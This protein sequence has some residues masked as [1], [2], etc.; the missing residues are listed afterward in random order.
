MKRLIPSTLVVIFFAFLFN[1][2]CDKENDDVI[3]PV[4]PTNCCTDTIIFQLANWDYFSETDQTFH[5]TAG[6]VTQ[7]SE[8]FK[9]FGTS[10]RHGS[11]ISTKN[12]FCLK[13]KTIKTKWKVNGGTTLNSFAVS[14]HYDKNAASTDKVN[15]I[16]LNFFVVNGSLAGAT[17]IQN[18]TWYYTRIKFNETDALSVTSTNNY[19][20]AGGPVISSATYQI[21]LPAGYPSIYSGD[22]YG[23]TSTY[24][25]VAEYRLLCNGN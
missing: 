17:T 10:F 22:T 6:N 12:P 13:N 4:T 15:T 7:T 24:M 3:T 5:P 20:D 25:V 1:L 21:K 19:D 23:G 18:D 8:G 2:S 16:D 9:F 14:L 11:R